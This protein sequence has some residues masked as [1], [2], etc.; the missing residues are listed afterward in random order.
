MTANSLDQRMAKDVFKTVMVMV[1]LA[2]KEIEVAMLRIIR[3]R[4]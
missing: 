2:R 3:I 4:Q 1:M